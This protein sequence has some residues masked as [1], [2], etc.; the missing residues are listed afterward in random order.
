[1]NTCTRTSSIRDE[2]NKI[3]RLT[4]QNMRAHEDKN[5]ETVFIYSFH[6]CWEKSLDSR[7][8]I[9]S[10]CWFMMNLQVNNV[11]FSSRMLEVVLVFVW[12]GGKI[13]IFGL[14]RR[15]DV[16]MLRVFFLPWLFS[17][18]NPLRSVFWDPCFLGT[19][20]FVQKIIGYIRP[21]EATRRR[22][23]LFDTQI[24]FSANFRS[25]SKSADFQHQIWM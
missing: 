11:R 9:E 21:R 7:G 22:S 19:F 18:R 20:F 23:V 5:V 4:G 24:R 14:V 13:W 1:M 17:E 6:S 8:H 15:W 3:I 16:K 12:W 2:L 25:C 10:T